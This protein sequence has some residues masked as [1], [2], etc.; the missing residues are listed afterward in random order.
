MPPQPTD[1]RVL[2]ESLFDL[3]GVPESSSADQPN[4][5]GGTV[6]RVRV[7]PGQVIAPR[8]RPTAAQNIP[9]GE[10]GRDGGSS[11]RLGAQPDI[12]RFFAGTL[13]IQDTAAMIHRMQLRLGLTARRG[14][15]IAGKVRRRIRKITRY[16]IE[17][18]D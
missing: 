16:V 12:E 14:P 2:L 13:G 6:P 18:E 1:S 11:R 7:F 17:V 3:C 8:P 4:H 15:M 9:G 10:A 5:Q